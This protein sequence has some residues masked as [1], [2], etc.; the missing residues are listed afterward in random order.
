MTHPQW[1]ELPFDERP[2]LT[3]FLIHLTRSTEKV[4][5]TAFDNLLRILQTGKIKGSHKGFIQGC[6]PSCLLHGRSFFIFEV[7]AD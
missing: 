4:W 2:D 3:P 7:S 1:P 6:P 5:V